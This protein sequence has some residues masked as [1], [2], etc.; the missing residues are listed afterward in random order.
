MRPAF[1][2]LTLTLLPLAAAAQPKPDGYP[3]AVQEIRVTA[4]PAAAPAPAFR[5]HFL[6]EIHEQTPGNAALLY[7]TAGQQL[8]VVRSPDAQARAD[9]DAIDKHLQTP[10]ADLPRDEVRALL[11]RYQSPLHQFRL[12]TRRDRCDF[13][14]PFRT[15]GF[16]TLLPYLNDA[17]AL[18]RLAA[19]SARLKLADRDFAGAV[20]D[21]GLPLVQA[22][23]LNENAFLIQLLVAAS[24][25]QTPLTQLP[26]WIAQ[27]GAPN[28]Y[29]A[30]SAL[31]APTLDARAAMQ[32][33][34]AGAYY[35]I[36]QLADARAGR[37]TPQQWHQA[38][39]TMTQVRSV[40]H[41]GPLTVPSPTPDR[42]EQAMIA[43]MSVKEY[44][45][46]KRHLVETEGRPA[47]QV[48]AMTVAQVIGLYHVA[49]FEFWT[50]ELDKGLTLPFPQGL[51]VITQSE[52]KM[53]AAMQQNPWSLLA[54]FAPSI[55]LA[56]TN[57]HKADRT[58]AAWRTIEAVR[59][60]AATH[61]GQPPAQLTDLTD[62][63]APLDPLTGRPFTYTVNGKE[64]TLEAPP[65]EAA[66]RTALRIIL[67]LTP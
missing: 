20:E 5:Y 42:G 38:L 29:W 27:D 52:E 66:P 44:P 16:R 50:Q 54:S 43:L 57:L 8:A 3:N 59:A 30:L 9:D 56:Y 36:P 4:R 23:H 11:A 35:S 18:A 39:K 17:R 47:E 19:L 67:N 61:N 53:R 37:L 24:V 51:R 15:E 40:T 32:M 65:I 45:L 22:R 25:A 28:L 26:D 49:Q 63:P 7:L 34:R 2:L 58:I 62:T 12:A 6:P 21:L 33:E 64:V 13:E 31:P 1:T 10:I 55:R 41:G 46:A 48:E 60:H 14:P